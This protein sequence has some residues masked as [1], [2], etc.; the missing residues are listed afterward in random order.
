VLSQ[1]V[2]TLFFGQLVRIFAAKWI[3]VASIVVFEI[4]SVLCSVS[5]N[6]HELIAGRTIAGVGAA[7][8]CA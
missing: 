4:G 2:F 7:G 5:Q 1:T 8:M 6:V 3:L